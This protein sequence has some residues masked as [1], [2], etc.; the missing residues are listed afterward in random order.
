MP[1]RNLFSFLSLK[2]NYFALFPFSIFKN[3]ALRLIYL[4]QSS[5]AVLYKENY[6]QLFLPTVLHK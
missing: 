5:L 2:Y 1:D 3:I 6:I 4:L